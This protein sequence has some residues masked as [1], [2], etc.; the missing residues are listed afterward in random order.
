MI[1]PSTYEHLGDRLSSA[2]EDVTLLIGDA[3]QKMQSNLIQSPNSLSQERQKYEKRVKASILLWTTQWKKWIG[4]DLP[5][6][7]LLGVK[8]ADA[9]VKS[10][11]TAK[12]AL[13]TGID[14]QQFGNMF[15]QG[16]S[17]TGRIVKKTIKAVGDIVV[18]NEGFATLGKAHIASAFAYQKEAYDLLKNT[19]LGIYRKADDIYKEVAKLTRQAL[20][21]EGNILTRQM[22]SNDMMKRFAEKGIDSIVYKNGARYGVDTYSEM[23]GR[24]MSSRVSQQGTFNRFQE[25][26]YDLV[27]VSSHFNCCDLCAPYEGR[28]FSLSGRS[29]KYPP[30]SQAI[31][32]GLFHPNCLHDTSAYFPGKSQP[33]ETRVDP[34]AQKLIDEHGYKKAQKMTYQASQKQRGIERNIRKWKKESVYSVDPNR[35]K[36]AKNKVL[37]WQKAQRV[38]IRENPFLRRKYDRE[39]IGMWAKTQPPPPIIP[40]VT[41]VKGKH[42]NFPEYGDDIKY[43]EKM[44]YSNYEA[45][46][47]S[48]SIADY[49]ADAEVTRQIRRA[50][51]DPEG[52]KKWLDEYKMGDRAVIRGKEANYLESYIKKEN[53]FEGTIYR[54]MH[55]DDISSFKEG[56]ILDMK[57]V[58]SWTSENDVARYFTGAQDTRFG[59]NRDTVFK[60][61]KVIMN[62]ENKSGVSINAFS[63][64]RGTK[65]VAEVLV[66]KDAMLKV[67][68]IKVDGNDVQI[69][70]EEVI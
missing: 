60:K 58:S 44:G 27:R 68:T 55:M 53:P 25:H 42:L 67:K 32:G 8:D 29:K 20:F 50:Q 14:V 19:G 5:N 22:I 47:I 65:D 45:H 31:R 28:I 26:G 70:L 24:T 41:P 30:L 35:T 69:I 16:T 4:E 7:Y 66:S 56:M 57:G 15:L 11:S 6:A 3:V 34:E 12:S 38:H 52:L 37:E 63:A 64:N 2:G 1:N 21:K 46:G 62:V 59:V 36:F 33:L 13:T 54:G 40:K 18:K 51:T 43:L 17:K 49:T 48:D 61:M 23:V 10:V 39:S 9:T